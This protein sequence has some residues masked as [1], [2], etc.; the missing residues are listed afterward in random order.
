MSLKANNLVKT[1][2]GRRVVNE[3]SFDV[4]PGEI[5]GLLGPNG[6]GKTTSF[7]MV[8]GLVKPENGKIELFDKDITKLPIHERSRAG[9]GYLTQ[10]PSI[11]RKL[12]VA[13]N[14]K[15]IWDVL[16]IYS[17]KQKEEELNQLLNEFNLTKLK[18]SLALS[19]SGGERRR[20]E[21]ARVLAGK[22]KFILLDEPFTGIDP[23]AIQD[24]Q[25]L[26]ADLKVKRNIGILLTD[27]NPRATLAITDRAYI[28][29]DGKIL[30]AGSAKEIAKNPIALK[31][32]LGE[33]FTLQ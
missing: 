16:G 29:Q 7:D 33:D 27:H 14:I 31:Y 15:F 21:I 8:V 19:L 1:Y 32:Y 17:E 22:P 24:I 12:T 9:V 13:D 20:V 5:V 10:E 2:S 3:I 4:K 28:I 11:F 23:I 25:K 6:A 30:I 18:D 26:I